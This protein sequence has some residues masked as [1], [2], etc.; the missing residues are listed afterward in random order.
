MAA[1]ETHEGS[2]QD[3]TVTR[4]TVAEFI[5][6][7]GEPSTFARHD[8]GCNYRWSNVEYRIRH[9]DDAYVREFRFR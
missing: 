3:W 5:R 4:R 2:T 8:A 1:S 6:H 9:R 7:G